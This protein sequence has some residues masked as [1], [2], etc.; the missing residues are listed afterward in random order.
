MTIEMGGPGIPG[1]GYGNQ[2]NSNQTYQQPR[3]DNDQPPAPEV[4]QPTAS[5]GAQPGNGPA[6][7]QAAQAG[8][9][10]IPP[11]DEAETA[12]EVA[13]D[14]GYD[15]VPGFE[16]SASD[17]INRARQIAR[18]LNHATLSSDH[19]ML[20]LTMDQS[21]RRLL[22]RVGDVA[23]LRAVAMR[24]LGKNYDKSDAGDQT[25]A[26]TSDLADIGKK[27]RDAAAEREQMVS[28]SDLIGAFPKA[29]G[30]LTYGAGESSRAVA[31]IET[32]ETRVI[33][34]V[35]NAVT[36]IENAIVDAV[37]RQ[38]QSVQSMLA[39]LSSKQSQEWELRQKAFMDEIRQQVREAA[40]TQVAAALKDL[41]AALEK[42]RAE[43]QTPVEE[44]ET[45]PPTEATVDVSPSQTESAPAE[46][47]VKHKPSWSW[48][49]I[50]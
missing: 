15:Q 14:L 30:R 46:L 22:E 7:N 20:A 3:A 33:P 43:T 48:L 24:K 6:A 17:C 28:I 50:F 11:Q 31:V 8:A 36:R 1:F 38:H 13:R 34:G 41:N 10:H 37:Q 35:N 2:G 47:E 4:K 9:A 19:L 18:S 5:A 42:T 16:V 29:D 21:A 39:D 32:I 23:Q 25:P 44:P 12:E 27:A 40:N 45:T 26:P 49:T